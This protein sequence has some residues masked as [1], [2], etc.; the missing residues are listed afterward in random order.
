MALLNFPA[1]P[2]LN[3]VYSA[4]GSSWM[5]TGERWKRIADPG[6]QGVQGVQGVQGAQGVQGI[7]V[8]GI[9]GV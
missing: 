2:T 5:W 6:E 4:N 3:D 8:H 1:S 9:Q 7:Q